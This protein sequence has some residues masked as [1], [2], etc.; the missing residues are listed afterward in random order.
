MSSPSTIRCRSVR[1]WWCWIIEGGTACT[2]CTP[3][4]YKRLDYKYDLISGNV[5]EVR[6]QQDQPDEYRHRYRY[7]ADNRITEVHTTADGSNWHRDARYT[8]YPHGPLARTELGSFTVQ[9]I[10]HAYTL[11]GWLKGINGDLLHPTTDMGH[12]GDL[13]DGDPSNDAIGRD[14]YALSLGYY[15][16]TDYM[17]ITPD[18]VNSPTTR[19]FA[20]VGTAGTANTVSEQHKP[21]YNG[22]IAHTVNTL[23]PSTQWS[24][25]DIGQVLAQV[26]HYDQLNRLRVTRAY[27][28][29]ALANNT[30]DGVVDATVNRYRSVYGYDANGNIQGAARFDGAGN[31]YD[32]LT[33]GYHQQADDRPVSN[34]LYHVLDDADQPNQFVNEGPDGAEDIPYTA[35]TFDPQ[36][37]AMNSTYNYG[38][39]ALGNLVR[40]TREDIADIEWTVAGKVRHLAR[41][42]GSPRKELTF[43]YGASG[44]RITKTVADPD[45]DAEG[46]REHYIRDAQ[47]NI[48]ATY[49]YTNSGSAS[50]QLTERPLYGS[51]RLGSLRKP[52]EL[53][54]LATFNAGAANPVQQVDLNY[55]LTDH[56]GNVTTVLTGRLLPQLGMGN[57]FQPELVSNQGYEPFGSLLP[58]R[59]YS[60]SSYN[61]GFQG[62]IKD[63]E[64]HGATG[65]SYAFEYRIHDPRIGRFLSIDPLVRDYPWNSPYAFS[66]NRVINSVELEGLEASIAIDGSTQNGPVDLAAINAGLAESNPDLLSP[67]NLSKVNEAIAGTEGLSHGA[68]PIPIREASPVQRDPSQPTIGPC[69]HCGTK[70]AELNSQRIKNQLALQESWNNAFMADPVMAGKYGGAN[71]Y[72]TL[73][74]G[75]QIVLVPELA[76]EMPYYGL[77]IL[78]REAFFTRT[79]KEISAMKGMTMTEKALKWKVYKDNRDFVL[80]AIDATYVRVSVAV[81]SAQVARLITEGAQDPEQTLRQQLDR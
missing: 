40:D 11:Q 8:Y 25:G 68:Y 74:E 38:Y 57:Q 33:Y 73:I 65:T 32:H 59:N 1:W 3:Y 49:R 36:E 75:A 79:W 56:L 81:S 7:D 39:D 70:A 27:T 78:S 69:N 30:W 18:W 28:G 37:P 15:G 14:A 34:R 67:D 9:G 42:V 72:P 6:Y 43:G 48:M 17:A 22:N 55:E 60:S 46:Y 26:Y 2:G 44:Q 53:H 45:G 35:G 4:R 47:G 62:Q 66:E 58:G 51:S 50:L 10:D 77:K 21:L 19:P 52:V 54:S 80:K 5:K 24:S 64:M 16:D 12:D 41:P 71:Q 23:M 76:I 20:P 31:W 63:D 29:M 13:S 61:F